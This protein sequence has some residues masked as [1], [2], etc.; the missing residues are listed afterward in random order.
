MPEVG[1]DFGDAYQS[2][3]FAEYATTREQDGAR[4]AIIDTYDPTTQEYHLA[5][6][7]LGRY[8][9][10]DYFDSK[11]QSQVLVS[12]PSDPAVLVGDDLV[13]DLNVVGNEQDPASDGPFT[14]TDMGNDGTEVVIDP[15]AVIQP[16]DNLSISAV[17]AFVAGS[18]V[19]GQDKLVYELVTTGSQAS[20]NRIPVEIDPADSNAEVLGKLA[21]TLEAELAARNLQVSVEYTNGSSSL[22]LV[23]HDDEDGVPVGTFQGDSQDYLVFGETVVD[24]VN[25]LLTS[26]VTGFRIHWMIR[27]PIL[28]S[29]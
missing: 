8:V 17:H 19:L 10:D 22:L 18:D 20:A 1:I 5:E 27:A 2:T 11:S 21:A 15:A 16:G 3:T 24:D 13:V 6:P 7:R 12:D 4:H 25:E 9:D 28:M 23:P 14:I 26:E 29:R